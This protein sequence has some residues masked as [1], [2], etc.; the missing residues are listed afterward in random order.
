MLTDPIFD[1]ILSLLDA[2]NEG[3]KRDPRFRSPLRAVQVM[4]MALPYRAPASQSPGRGAS[5]TE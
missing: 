5:S 3:L 4:N 1:P 2:L